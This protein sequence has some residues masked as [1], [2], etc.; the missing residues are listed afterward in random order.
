MFFNGIFMRKLLQKCELLRLAI[1]KCGFEARI[2]PNDED[3]FL[4]E[5]LL[6]RSNR[7]EV[8]F[9]KICLGQG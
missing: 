3:F 7:N 9:K 2:L 1:I 6:L 8:K 4:E 5:L